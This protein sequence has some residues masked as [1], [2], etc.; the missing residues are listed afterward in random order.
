[1]GSLTQAFAR[2]SLGRYPIWKIGFE[3]RHNMDFKT[4]FPFVFLFFLLINS[5][6]GH[7]DLDCTKEQRDICRS[8][9]QDDDRV[10]CCRVD[11]AKNK[12]STDASSFKCCT[13]DEYHDQFPK[14]SDAVAQPRSIVK[15]V[16]KLVFVIVGVAVFVIVA[17]VVCCC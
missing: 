3:K 17:C 7:D 12:T 15:G 11:V 4:K 2:V 13:E 14:L 1:M 16:L 10:E 5:V 8:R 9:R 6:L